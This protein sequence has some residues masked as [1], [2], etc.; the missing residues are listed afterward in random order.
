MSADTI[1]LLDDDAAGADTGTGYR[2]QGNQGAKEGRKLVQ[3]QQL[4]RKINGIAVLSMQGNWQL[5]LKKGSGQPC[6]VD[7]EFYQTWQAERVN[8]KVAFEKV[9]FESSVF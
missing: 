2:F 3:G 5:A 7:S 9:A 4:Q 8:E 1:E 6:Y